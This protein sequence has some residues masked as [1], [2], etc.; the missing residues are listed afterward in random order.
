MSRHQYRTVVKRVH[1]HAGRWRALS[2]LLALS[3]CGAAG[4]WWGLNMTAPPAVLDDR[5]ALLTDQIS[6]LLLQAEADQQTLNELRNHLTDQAADIAALED[7]LAFYRGVLAPEEGDTPVVLRDPELVFTGQARRWQFTMVIHR[8]EAGESVYRGQ[9]GLRIRGQGPG[10]ATFVSV[11]EVDSADDSS[12]FRLRF[13]YLQ[14]LQVVISLPEGFVP[15][16]IES[17]VTLTGPVRK[18][19]Q[20]SD[21]WQD[22]VSSSLALQP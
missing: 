12:V 21:R 2:W 1:P 16:T 4:V 15:E 7:M 8:G 6:Q 11:S 13:R 3:A 17:V 9:L 14:Q 5:R 19:A 22:L 10:E 18:T 20:R